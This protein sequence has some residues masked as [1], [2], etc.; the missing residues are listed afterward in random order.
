MGRDA[1]INIK[2]N[3]EYNALQ[4]EIEKLKADNSLL[5]EQILTILEKIDNLQ[6]EIESEKA[7]VSAKE[8][9]YKKEKQVLENE[10]KDI[11]QQVDSF[12]LKRKDISSGDL[13]PDILDRYN[14]IIEHL[15]E[16]AVVSVKNEACQG[17]FRT[18]RAQV[19]SELK[20]GKL[21]TC[22]NCTRIIYVDP[23][24]S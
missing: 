24:D 6:A 5:E 16:L 7:D 4:L 12:G 2:T 17:C 14:R 19:L 13:K 21:L 8:S 10:M 3:K 18:V 23:A 15:G 22:E 1:I 11:Q 9:V 20:L